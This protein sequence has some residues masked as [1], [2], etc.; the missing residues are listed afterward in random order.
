MTINPRLYNLSVRETDRSP[1]A[2]SIT[3]KKYHRSLLTLYN[4][5]YSA[6][7]IKKQLSLQ[8]KWLNIEF[9]YLCRSSI[10]F[11]PI[12]RLSFKLVTETPIT[13]QKNQLHDQSDFQ[14]QDRHLI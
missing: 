2:S 5:E 10:F 6:L 9:L 3:F 14:A 8:I 7:K 12:A 11:I 1:Y 4:F 13:K